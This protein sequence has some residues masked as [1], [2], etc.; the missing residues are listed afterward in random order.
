VRRFTSRETSEIKIVNQE[1]VI[2][3]T[4]T[5]HHDPNFYTN[6][7]NMTRNYYWSIKISDSSGH[8]QNTIVGLS[9]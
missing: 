1:S 9:R 3:F 4:L 7:G 6:A 8:F 5:N 2:N